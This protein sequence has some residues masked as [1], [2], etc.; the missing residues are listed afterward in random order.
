MPTAGTSN[1]DTVQAKRQDTASVTTAI[2]SVRDSNVNEELKEMLEL[3]GIGGWLIAFLGLA[4]YI[5]IEI[6]K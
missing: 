2:R 1:L 6:M 4:V 3:I 5:G